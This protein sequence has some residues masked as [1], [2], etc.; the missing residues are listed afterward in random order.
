MLN[1]KTTLSAIGADG[2]IHI[3]DTSK[4]RI[5]PKI[6]GRPYTIHAEMS[7]LKQAKKTKGLTLYIIRPDC[8][9]TSKPCLNCM[10]ILS[11]TDFRYIVYTVD[12]VF[13]KEKMSSIISLDGFKLS[14]G[15][16]WRK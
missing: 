14:S 3:Q 10:R 6:Q 12:G 15:E 5:G 4:D 2:K 9:G 16:R 7:V 8:E 13:V 11:K 1:T